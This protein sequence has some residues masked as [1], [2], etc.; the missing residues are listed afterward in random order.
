MVYE[1]LSSGRNADKKDVI[2]LKNQIDAFDSSWEKSEDV[3]LEA[4]KLVDSWFEKIV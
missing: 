4:E 3:E 1:K 2:E